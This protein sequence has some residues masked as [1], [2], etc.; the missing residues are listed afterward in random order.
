M[1]FKEGDKVQFIRE[2]SRVEG[3]VKEFKDC[4]PDMWYLIDEGCK[5]CKDSWIFGG[6]L[7]PL[8]PLP[9]IPQFVADWIF[10]HKAF[11]RDLLS[12]LDIENP[13]MPKSVFR[14]LCDNAENQELFAR[15][16]MDGYEV[17]D[18]PLYYVKLADS[19]LD[20]L[21]VDK[22]TGK[23]SISNP[24]PLA[25]CRVKFTEKE[26]KELDERYWQFAVPVSESEG[27]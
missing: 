21:R 6:H 10:E 8:S 14:W 19:R 22:T 12:T 20:Y 25:N 23:T 15:A 2:G 5:G 24:K 4:S 9:V 1:K 13:A 27:N 17:E 18:E 7:I 16:W 26:I 11:E 3:V